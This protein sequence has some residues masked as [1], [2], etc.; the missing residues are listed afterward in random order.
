ML[1]LSNHVEFAKKKFQDHNENNTKAEAEY[2][3]LVID[4]F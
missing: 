4:F 2:E 3:K 1:K